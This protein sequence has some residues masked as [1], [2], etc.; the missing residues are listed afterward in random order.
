[1]NSTLKFSISQEGI[2]CLLGETEKKRI[3]NYINI[4]KININRDTNIETYE[5]EYRRRNT[6]TLTVISIDSE[7]IQKD[8]VVCIFVQIKIQLLKK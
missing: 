8:K 7:Q 4:K 6:N 1:M 5:L 3:S 2:D